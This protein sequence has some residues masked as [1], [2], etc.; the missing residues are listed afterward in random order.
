MG[1][2]NNLYGQLSMLIR[3]SM[4]FWVWI[5]ELITISE[6]LA[7]N[8]G[9]KLSLVWHKTTSW[10]MHH[11]IT[12]VRSTPVVPSW[13]N[14]STPWN[15]FKALYLVVG[16]KNYACYMFHG[17]QNFG[18]FQRFYQDAE[19]SQWCVSSNSTYNLYII[20]LVKQNLFEL[21]W[22]EKLSN[23]HAQRHLLY[24]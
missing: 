4:R 21:I 8:S 15:H 18:K 22:W 12:V 19:F 9:I 14:H 16:L 10:S 17:I 11:R 7:A 1:A 3:N 2:L 23:Q 20:Q 6:R 24:R 13:I 5:H